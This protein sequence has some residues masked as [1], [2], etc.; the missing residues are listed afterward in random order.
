MILTHHP[1]R[2]GAVLPLV[3]VCLIILFAFVALAIDLGVMAVSRTQAQNAADSAAMAGA[4][5]LTGDPAT[6]NN[7]DNVTPNADAAAAANTVLGKAVQASQVQV[8]IGSYTYDYTQSKF[9]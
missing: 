5:T 2:R 6:N 4:R 8:D 3:V 7:Y 1:R 9:V